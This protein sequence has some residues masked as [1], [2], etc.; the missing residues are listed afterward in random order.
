[1]AESKTSLQSPGISR[2]I[3]PLVFALCLAGGAVLEWLWFRGVAPLGFLPEP[4]RIFIGVVIGFGGFSF[5]GWGFFHFKL[6]GTTTTLIRPVSQ[7]VMD[8]AY[9]FSR[10]PMY[11]GFVS[12]LLGFGIVIDSLPLLVSALVMFLYLDRFVI[13]R[14][15]AYLSDAFDESYT[16]YCN[17]VRRWL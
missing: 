6:V 2:A 11:V 17:K 7:L 8:G 4:L 10:N 5:M 14:E 13:Q 9:R 12:L 1:M 15:E 3:P 16:S